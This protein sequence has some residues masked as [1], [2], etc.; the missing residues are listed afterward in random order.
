[1]QNNHRLLLRLAVLTSLIFLTSCA[2]WNII[3]K[4]KK[5]IIKPKF[6]LTVVDDKLEIEGK[7]CTGDNK[8]VAGC[9]SVGEWNIALI[10]FKLVDSPGYFFDKFEIC[11][12]DTR[13]LLIAAT[14]ENGSN[15]KP[16]QLT[17]SLPNMRSRMKMASLI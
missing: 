15:W 2:E 9:V 1:M 4:S 13:M 16:S 14:L 3:E 10:R 12:G 8:D 7:Y 17:K 5:D 6:K 11:N